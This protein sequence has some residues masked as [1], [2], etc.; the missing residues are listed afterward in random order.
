MLAKSPRIFGIDVLNLS[1]KSFSKVCQESIVPGFK[2]VNQVKALSAI[3][4]KKALHK[5]ASSLVTSLI[6]DL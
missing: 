1:K 5:M 4:L 2:E 6:A 3:V